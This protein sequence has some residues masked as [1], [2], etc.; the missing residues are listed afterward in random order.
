MLDILEFYLKTSASPEVADAVTKACELFE[1]YDLPGY[2]DVYTD[3]LMSSDNADFNDLNTNII[4]LT[5]E[6]QRAVLEQLLILVD[7]DFTIQ[8]GNLLLE[9]MSRIEASDFN[10]EII[11]L[12]DDSDYDNSLCEILSLVSGVSTESFYPLIENIDQCVIDR[13]KMVCQQNSVNDTISPIDTVHV[14]QVINRL[15]RYKNFVDNKPLFIYDSIKNGQLVDL[16][17]KAYY[18]EMPEVFWSLQPQEKAIQLIAGVL[19]SSDVNS[20]PKKFITEQLSR[21][22]TSIDHITPIIV[23]FDSILNKFY[24]E[25][26]KINK[27][28]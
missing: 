19:V 11:S 14:R 25:E 6:L 20:N 3:L 1:D 28:M 21:T 17:F 9:S 8:Q 10:E 5:I 12:C 22:M 7:S 15:I 18:D 24:S 27:G 2:Q 13:I 4:S 23:A 16:P 26:S